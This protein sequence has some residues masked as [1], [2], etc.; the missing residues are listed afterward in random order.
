MKKN[1]FLQIIALETSFP[2]PWGFKYFL[3]DSSYSN[4]SARHSDMKKGAD[5]PTLSAEVFENCGN[6]R[7]LED[8]SP[9][10]LGYLAYCGII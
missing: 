2:N 6:F 3:V 1:Q 9:F 7:I 10:I 8:Y 4:F 5:A